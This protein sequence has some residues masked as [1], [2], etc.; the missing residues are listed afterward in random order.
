MKNMISVTL[1]GMGV[2]A[3]YEVHAFNGV[4]IGDFFMS[5]DGFYNWWP[6]KDRDGYLPAYILYA[7]AE[8]LTL[9]NANWE[10]QIARLNEQ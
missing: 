3:E 1:L 10:Q 8:H 7:L 6:V 2:P 5:E 9:L 4:K